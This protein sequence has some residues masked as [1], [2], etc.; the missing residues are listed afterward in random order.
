METDARNQAR[1]SLSLSTAQ[2]LWR[3]R[4]WLAITVFAAACTATL[5]VVAFLPNLY[6][7]TA[8]VLVERQQ[9]PEGF[10]RPSVTGDLE[11]RLYTVSQE[12]LSRERLAALSQRFGLYPELRQTVAPEA[13][14]QRMR[15]DI[16]LSLKGAE[17][18]AGQSGPGA[19]IA[20][21]I[22]Y[23]GRD[24]VTVA[25]VTNTLASFYVEENTRVRERQAAGTA[26]FL[27]GQVEEMKQRLDEQ[28]RALRGVKARYMGEL[29]EQLE[30]NRATL[31]RYVSQ[32]RMNSEA[33]FRARERREGAL[34]RLAEGTTTSPDD[35][36]A[37][38]FRLRQ[39]LAALRTR[40]TDKYPD[41]VRIKADIATLEAQMPA[42][43]KTDAGDPGHRPPTLAEIDAELKAL[44]EEEARL[45]Q[46]IATYQRRVEN[47]PKSDQELRAASRDYEATRDLYVSMLKRYED[48]QL[49][50]SME[51]RQKGEL[52]RILDPALPA[53]GPMAPNRLLLALVGLLASAGLGVAAAV[54]L[55]RFDT[56]FHAADELRAFTRV[57]V[58][59][60]I[61]RI[62]TH[63]DAAR[64]RRRFAARA[65]VVG[66]AL[67]LIA[68][69][70]YHL[71]SGNEGL[72]VTLSRGSWGGA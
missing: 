32:L 25:E 13:V 38:L 36:A 23:R 35:P 50:E 27:R 70:A 22:S 3:R 49:A 4:K 16:R 9:V 71:A 43:P 21:A 7:S 57:P 72:V 11:T 8:T 55:E 40:F 24:P 20:F 18:P 52:F 66:V 34:R 1:P 44:K 56:S 58:L 14:A 2:S 42:A 47:V 67:A 46:G 29:P 69:A 31:E 59:A 5:G 54:L 19:T 64:R 51:Q 45:Q 28:E 15:Q 39:E 33:Q 6:G 37:R 12:I 30:V 41:V 63:A 65:V 53:R 60:S 26:D 61:P 68:A 10:V 17:A 62:V 48:A